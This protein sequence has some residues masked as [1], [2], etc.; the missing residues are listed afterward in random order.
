MANDFKSRT[1]ELKPRERIEAAGSAS[2]ANA[3]ELL[4]IILKTGAAG[5]VHL[6][7]QSR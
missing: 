3:V 7:P 1:I 6:A 2:V 5:C 4:A